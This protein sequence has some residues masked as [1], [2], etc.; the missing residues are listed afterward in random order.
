[1][2]DRSGVPGVHFRARAARPPARTHTPMDVDGCRSRCGRVRQSHSLRGFSAPTQS[3]D[4][5]DHGGGLER[6]DQ[7]THQR[8]RR[9]LMAECLCDG[10][11]TNREP[12]RPCQPALRCPPYRP[13]R[14]P[15]TEDY[16]R[17]TQ[18]K[19]DHTE[20]PGHSCGEVHDQEGYPRR[21]LPGGPAH[22]GTHQSHP[23]R[24]C[25]AFRCSETAYCEPSG[26]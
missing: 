23:P 6:E 21:S 9:P 14:K 18:N 20:R 15:P 26:S 2:L 25:G 19:H 17:Q 11:C 16:H 8:Q 13:I 24:R 12:S 7:P 10:A 22:S 1:M 5:D 3:D 4:R